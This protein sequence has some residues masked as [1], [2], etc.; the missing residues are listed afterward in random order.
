VFIEKSVG[1]FLDALASN[2]PIPGGGS[3]AALAGASAAALV[4]MV[5]NLTIGKRGYERVQEAVATLL[6]QSEA[7]R[8][9]LERLSEDDA[10]VYGRVMAA[11]RQQH[12]TAEQEQAR[13]VA[14]QAALKDAA[15]VPLTIAGRCAQVIDLALPA[16]EMGNQWA[17]SDAGAGVL[18]A[19]ASMRAALLN[20]YINLSG[21]K[22]ERYAQRTLE[23][24]AA[25]TSGKEE[26]KERVLEI[27][28]EKMG[29]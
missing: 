3:A 6:R 5:C 23:R 12:E 2:D 15:G 7:L 4:S 26:T 1:E 19:E 29:G 8:G 24:I 28:Q 11:Y 20:V 16:A 17:V 27:V 18:L 10:K 21:I 22:D 14:L 9:Q 25:I 13:E